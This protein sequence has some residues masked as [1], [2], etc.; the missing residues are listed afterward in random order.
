[1]RVRQDECLNEGGRCE[2]RDNWGVGLGRGV[3]W[4]HARTVWA[5]LARPSSGFFNAGVNSKAHHANYNRTKG[6]LSITCLLSS[7]ISE[8]E[9][10]YGFIGA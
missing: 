7:C 8:N 9:M 5:E 1:M 10:I 2:G 4:T 6:P 3:N